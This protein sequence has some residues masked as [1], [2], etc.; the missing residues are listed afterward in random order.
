MFDKTEDDEWIVTM[1]PNINPLLFY[2]ETLDE[3]I[4][5]ALCEYLHQ[6]PKFETVRKNVNMWW[7]K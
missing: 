5:H 1:I 7:M 3:A 6:E 2:Y 4:D